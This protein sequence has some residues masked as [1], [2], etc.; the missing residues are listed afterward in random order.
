MLEVAVGNRR[1][2]LAFYQTDL[3]GG[4]PILSVDQIKGP[5]VW[6][7]Y[8]N[9]FEEEIWAKNP[10]MPVKG[11]VRVQLHTISGKRVKEETFPGAVARINTGDLPAGVYLISIS[12]REGWFTKKMVKLR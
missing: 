8:P 6:D 11:N 10:I 3:E 2:G 7:V 12:D 9:P 5:E 4:D 1:G